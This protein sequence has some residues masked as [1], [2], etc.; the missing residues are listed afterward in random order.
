M[1]QETLDGGRVMSR[2]RYRLFLS[3][4]C[5]AFWVV[6]VA[7]GC[8]PRCGRVCTPQGPWQSPTMQATRAL[9]VV[10]T[11][12]L[13]ILRID[14][15][16][17]RPSCIG[18]GGV[19]EYHLPAGMH[20]VTASFCYAGPVHGGLIG[21]VRGVPVT[22]RHQFVAG[23]EYVPMYRQYIRRR[24]PA[25]YLL[26]AVGA[27]MAGSDQHWSLTIADLAET[28][29]DPEPE[30]VEARHYCTR[31]RGLAGTLDY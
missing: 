26:E 25:K 9:L 18:A 10:N 28:R 17:V 31:I 15:K 21:A 6:L 2:C 5:G 16:N 23:H 13:K 3:S 4:L 29:P 8:C 24:P 19:R 27:V 11:E 14:G 12:E 20:S 30:I 22:L 1:S 7:S